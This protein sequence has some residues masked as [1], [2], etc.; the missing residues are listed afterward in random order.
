MN[1]TVYKQKNKL[2]KSIDLFTQSVGGYIYL[3]RFNTHSRIQSKRNN[4]IFHKY[5]L[6]YLFIQKQE[7]AQCGEIK[8]ICLSE[9]KTKQETQQLHRNVFCRL[10]FH[11]ND[12]FK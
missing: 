5:I 4:A 7:T 6:E 3:V 10:V 11:K 1:K 2:I 9:N 12:H 8:G